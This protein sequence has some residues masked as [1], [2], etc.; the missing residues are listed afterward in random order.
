MALNERRKNSLA[1]ICGAAACAIVLALA[2]AG[3]WLFVRDGGERGSADGVEVELA[4]RDRV[5]D[6]GVLTPPKASSPPAP[7]VPESREISQTATRVTI[8][9]DG[10]VV[11]PSVTAAAFSRAP[12]AAQDTTPINAADPALLEHKGGLALPKI[13]EDGRMA[14]RVYARPFVSRD[15]RSR[16]AVIVG[17][18]GLSPVATEAAIRRLPGAVTLAFHPDAAD[19]G[20]WAEMARRAGH[21]VLLSI[22]MEP[23]DFPF[24]DPG[25]RALL[26]NL[27]TR[28]NLDRLERTL[29]RLTGFVGVM[30]VMG[31]KFAQHEDGLRPVLETLNR[32]GVMYVEAAGAV[33][34]MAPRIATEI[35]LPRVIVDVVL[36]DEPSQAAIENQ[37]ARLEAVARERAV[38]VAL[39]RPYPVVIE[40]LSKWVATLKEKNLV[41]APASAIADR[42]F[43]P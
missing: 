39:A 7:H 2:L 41:L 27:D 8:G 16:V 12:L 26:T 42:Q 21:E 31:S 34:S 30:S 25:P 11:A 6:E 37:L 28:E 17:G 10:G 36:D 23:A 38:A 9:P 1:L 33:E 19:I 32:R 29:G 3:G 5:Q 43:L 40:G 14:L 15:E 13:A 20:K 24:D 22:P 18:L 4:A 35:G